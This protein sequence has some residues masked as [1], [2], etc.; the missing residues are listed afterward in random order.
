MSVQTRS[1]S[2][3][4][5]I[6][7]AAWTPASPSTG[8]YL[9]VH[10]YRSDQGL[11]QDAGVTPATSDGDPVGR[12]EDLTANADHLNQSTAANKPTLQNGATDLLNG[13]PVIRFDGTNDSLQGAYTTAGTLTQ[14]ATLFAVAALDAVSV[15]NDATTV[16]TDGDDSTNRMIFAK[17]S[18]GDPDNWRII[19]GA[20]LDGGAADS[21][22]HIWTV[23]FNI[24]ASQF[25]KDGVTEGGPGN[26]SGQTPDG[27]TAGSSYAGSSNWDGDITEIII[28]DANLPDADKNQVAQYLADRYG[29]GYTDI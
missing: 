15:N 4:R 10:W 2:H 12:W 14:P 20:Q 19:S 23:L 1:L 7:T 8:G 13:H 16:L 21:D 22:W 29:L 18:A 25:W 3:R 28:Y 11:W 24:L 27:L 17:T 5:R 26:T 9:P 6:L